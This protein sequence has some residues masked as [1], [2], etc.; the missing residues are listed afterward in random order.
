MKTIYLDNAATTQID[1]RVVKEMEKFMI[2]EFGNPSSLHEK[3]REARKAVE[4]AREIIANS[5]NA[6]PE[7]IIFTSGGTESNVLAIKGVAEANPEKKHII[8]SKIEHDCII[9]CCNELEKQGYRIT[10]IDVD[11][12]GFVNLDELEKAISP[13]TLVVSIIHGNNEIGTI[14]DLEKIGKICKSKKVYFH[15][16]ACQSYMKT[17]IDVRKQNLDLAT[18]NAHKIHGP[19]GIGVLYIRKGVKIK[20]IQEGG[21]QEREIRGGTENVPGIVGMA[22]AV[23]IYDK[24]EIE[25]MK[26]L[27][28]KMIKELERIPEIKLNGSREKR[29]YNNINVRFAGIEGESILMMLDKEGICVSTGSACSSKS[30]EPSHV[31][32]ALGLKPEESHGSIRISLGRFNTEKEINKFLKVIPKIVKDLRKISP[33]WKE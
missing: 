29:L 10:K 21:G 13:D 24:E 1:K 7:E 3:G 19:K 4:K 28:D 8:I 2:R 23:E 32:L 22:K 12:E 30:L 27:R 16:D 33:F 31:L 20:A 5:I 17:E 26:E 9:N 6:L 15:T 11:S 25:K 14:Q 18:L